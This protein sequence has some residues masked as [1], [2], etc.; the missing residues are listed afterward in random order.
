MSELEEQYPGLK[1]TKT[2]KSILFDNN[3]PKLH[4]QKRAVL[5]GAITG[6]TPQ[7]LRDMFPGLIEHDT[8]RDDGR[9][10]HIIENGVYMLLIFIGDKGIMFPTLRKQNEENLNFYGAARGEEFE[11]VIIEEK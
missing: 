10:Y 7:F 1:Y 9:F 11:I 4:G 5:C 3:Y 6:M 2:V 8:K